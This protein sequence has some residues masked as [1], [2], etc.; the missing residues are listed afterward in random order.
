MRR[1]LTA[2]ALEHPDVGYV[3]SMNFLAAFLLLHAKT[4]DAA[5]CLFR[6]LMSHPRLAL[7]K[8]YAPGLPLLVALAEALERLLDKHAPAAMRHLRSLRI[9]ALLFAQNWIMCVFTFSMPFDI[10]TSVWESFFEHGWATVLQVAV[11]L[12]RG[13]EPHL[14]RCDFEGAFALLRDAAALAPPDV[15]ERAEAGDVKFD[16]EDR[17]TVASVVDAVQMPAAGS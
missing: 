9:D 7:R 12:V 4:E 16:E 1:I 15:L 14:L 5:F 17:A 11:Q 13:C 10:A 2:V 6:R 3:Q 8:V